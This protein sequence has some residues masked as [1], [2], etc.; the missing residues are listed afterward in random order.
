M[1]GHCLHPLTLRSVADSGYPPS[2]IEVSLHI[3]EELSKGRTQMVRQRETNIPMR[4][5]DRT[6]MD[7]ETANKLTSG[8]WQM[9]IPLDGPPRDVIEE[10]ARANFPRENFEFQRI[11]E[12]EFE[13]M[14]A[15]SRNQRGLTED[16]AKTATEAQ[17]AQSASDVRLDAERAR[18]LTWFTTGARKFAALLQLFKTDTSYVEILGAE[19]QKALAPWDRTQVQGQFIFKCKPDSALRIDA[20]AR[21]KQMLDLYNLTA[22]DP[23]VARVELLKT[24]FRSYNVDP[25]RL[26]VEQLPEK[27]PEPPKVGISFKGEDLL[28]T[29]VLTFLQAQGVKIPPEM[30]MQAEMAGMVRTLAAQGEQEPGQQKHGGAAQQ[31]E[32]ISKHSLRGDGAAPVGISQRPGTP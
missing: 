8:V 14:W 11:A 17:I 9:N 25:S 21:R 15:M 31:A 23:N 13:E 2:D 32:H 5:F 10:I 6:R 4:G 27:G 19:G 20:A 26:V 24:L 28:L 18:V 12:L 7:P 3:S 1:M 16:S 29:P 22:N 30:L